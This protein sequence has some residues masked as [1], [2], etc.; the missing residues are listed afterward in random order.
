[1]TTKLGAGGSGPKAQ[2]VS[3]NFVDDRLLITLDGVPF[4][5]MAPETWRRLRTDLV[6]ERVTDPVKKDDA[7]RGEDG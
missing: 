6:A 1:M 3:W 4:M 7:G 5:W 2:H